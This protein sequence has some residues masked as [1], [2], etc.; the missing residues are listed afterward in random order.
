LV[1]KESGVII[2]YLLRLN[3]VPPDLA[4]GCLNRS[5]DSP[6]GSVLTDLQHVG[7]CNSR[8]IHTNPHQGIQNISHFVAIAT[9][10]PW[11][12]HIWMCWICWCNIMVLLRADYFGE[13]LGT[14]YN[15]PEVVAA[16]SPA[17][18]AIPV[19]RELQ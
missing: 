12:K 1:I 3:C 11:S 2:Y 5:T 4:P 9:S 7:T 14:N 16:F 19:S 17:V 18:N 10:R 13:N 6:S 8:L 15:V